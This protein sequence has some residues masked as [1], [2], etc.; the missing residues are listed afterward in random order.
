[1]TLL[2]ASPITGRTHQ[3]RVHF[4]SVKHPVVGDAVYGR[5]STLV[6][7]QFLHAWRLTLCHPADGREMSFEA[8]LA[9]DLREALER[10]GTRSWEPDYG[11]GPPSS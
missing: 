8:P 6:D 5:R 4:A 1:M 9:D 2:E 10:L 11:S 3:I 7:R